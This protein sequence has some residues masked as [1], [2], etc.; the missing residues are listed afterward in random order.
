MAYLTS[1][2]HK[3]K[4]I[5]ALQLLYTEFRLENFTILRSLHENILRDMHV[6]FTNNNDVPA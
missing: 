1:D 4:N 2:L 5:G 6:F 3:Q